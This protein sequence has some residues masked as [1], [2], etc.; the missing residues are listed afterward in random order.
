MAAAVRVVI[1]QFC[2]TSCIHGCCGRLEPHC[3]A[4]HHVALHIDRPTPHANTKKVGASFW[5]GVVEGAG[6]VAA[7]AATQSVG[8]LLADKPETVRA[9]AREQVQHGPSRAPRRRSVA[10]WRPGGEQS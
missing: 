3:G 1:C 8:G 7:D 9:W 6:G 2:A 10:T 4:A 5:T